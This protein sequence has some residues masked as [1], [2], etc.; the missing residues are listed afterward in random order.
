MSNNQ[1]KKA[2]ALKHNMYRWETEAY[3]ED[4]QRDPVKWERLARVSGR[5]TGR[6]IS[7]HTAL[8][9]TLVGNY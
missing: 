6:G 2:A 9:L 5:R 7:L 3:K 4:R 1:L 8:M